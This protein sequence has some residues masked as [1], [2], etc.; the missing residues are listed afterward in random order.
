MLKNLK[1]PRQQYC[2][3]GALHLLGA[4]VILNALDQRERDSR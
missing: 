4:L 1:A 3:T 2:F